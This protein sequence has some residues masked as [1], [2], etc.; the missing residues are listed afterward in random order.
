MNER[1]EYT[2][3]VR[4]VGIADNR[5]LE[6]E[7][8]GNADSLARAYDQLP[9]VDMAYELAENGSRSIDVDAKVYVNGRC[10][11]QIRQHYNNIIDL[12]KGTK[13]L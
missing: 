2:W 1:H 3:T 12:L 6:L 8:M 11:K 5:P 10:R 7:R 4:A 9:I 13:Q